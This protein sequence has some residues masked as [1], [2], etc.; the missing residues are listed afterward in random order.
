MINSVT[1]CISE[2]EK[3]SNRKKKTTKIQRKKRKKER[4]DE[5]AHDTLDHSS[6][7]CSDTLL[8]LV[9]CLEA[10]TELLAIPG[11]LEGL[12]G[13]LC[14]KGSVWRRNQLVIPREAPPHLTCHGWAGQTDLSSLWSSLLLCYCLPSLCCS[15]RLQFSSICFKVSF[16]GARHSR[17]KLHSE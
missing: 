8:W 4:L 11:R 14:W 16:L 9:T 3:L 7:L 10:G 5:S 13:C 1:W 15:W 17:R 6:P 12:R 2:N